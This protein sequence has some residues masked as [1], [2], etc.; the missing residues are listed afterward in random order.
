M[1]KLSSKKIV[2]FWFEESKLP[3]ARGGVKISV[4]VSDVLYDERS[5]FGHVQVFSTEFF[6]KMLVID[7]LIQ[8][9]EC[10]EF[11]YH[12]MM[13]LLPCLRFGSP[14][15]LLIIGG[16]DGGAAKQALRINSLNKIVEVEIDPSIIAVTQTY[17]PNIANGSLTN[18]RV[19]LI[20]GDGREYI[21]KTTNSFDVIVL[22]LTDPLPDS[23]AEALFS[24][25]FFHEVKSKLSPRG[26][27]AVQCGSLT[28]QPDE[29][30]ILHKRLSQ[31][32]LH[33]TL[34]SAVV[35]SYQLGQ[36][37]F[38]YGSSSMRTVT[39]DKGTGFE[40]IKGMCQYLNPK[41]YEASKI[42]PTY[43]KNLL[44]V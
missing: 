16:G 17:M 19:E 44:M 39:Y 37:G 4:L 23:P 14:Q 28:F 12:E 11:I 34:H 32:F 5:D 26:V 2:P 18:N 20:I 7:G 15:S 40:N 36:F 31:V 8:V 6:G 24:E 3:F 22:D 38:L 42:L 41:T 10:D 21:Q 9:T 25:E 43:L 35:P 30:R 1:H 29:V 13:V 33:V 27:V